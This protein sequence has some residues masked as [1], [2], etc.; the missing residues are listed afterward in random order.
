[1]HAEEALAIAD[2]ERILSYLWAQD[3]VKPRF[4]ERMLQNG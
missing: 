4:D 3:A 1:M 2:P